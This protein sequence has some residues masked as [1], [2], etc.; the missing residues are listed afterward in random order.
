M[1]PVTRYVESNGVHVAWQA[2]GDGPVDIVMIPGFA[3]H[4]DLQWGDRGFLRVMRRLTSFARVILFDKPGTGL[5][6]AVAAP[7][8]L[9]QQADDILAVMDAAGA[10]QPVIF[11]QS[12]GGP[13]SLLIASARPERVRSLVMFGVFVKGTADEQHPWGVSDDQW[14]RIESVL[15]HWGEGSM[16]DL[17]APSIAG[18]AVQRRLL[19]AFERAACSPGSVRAIATNARQLDLTSVLPTVRVP[20]LVLARDREFLGVEQ[21]RF[22]AN[23]VPDAVY[24]ELPGVDHAMTVGDVD[25]WID[26]VEEFVTGTKSEI[27]CERA[28]VTLLSV[29]VVGSTRRATELGDHRWREVLEAYTDATTDAIVEHGGRVIGTAGDGSLACFDGPRAALETAWEIQAI[30]ARSS[31]A[32]RAG[33]HSGLVELVGDDVAGIEVHVAARIGAMA[34]PGEVLVSEMARGLVGAGGVGFD[35]AGRQAL[36]GVDG[37]HQLWRARPADPLDTGDPV[38]LRRRDRALVWLAGRTKR[39]GAA[40]VARH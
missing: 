23:A 6:D 15:D 14:S 29:D 3:S 16:I 36:R 9:E 8:T 32:V 31:L 1:Q 28:L 25:G 7:R 4:L 17:V 19:A 18:S 13:V 22:I 40:R 20:T 11:G 35:D 27:D 34:G 26:R 24:V 10:Q 37:T 21:A 5:S 12:A 39:V 38:S 2:V 33:V 30:G